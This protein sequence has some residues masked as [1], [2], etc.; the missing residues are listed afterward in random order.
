MKTSIVL[1][2][3]PEFIKLAPIARELKSRGHQFDLFLSGQHTDMLAGLPEL[4]DL[5]TDIKHLDIDYS[6]PDLSHLTSHI[7]SELNRQLFSKSSYDL[8]FVQGDTTTAFATALC[9]F[10]NK[11]PVAHVEAGLRTFD[12]QSPFPEEFNR[13]VISKLTQFHFPPTASSEQYLLDEGVEKSGI[14]RCGNTVIDALNFVREHKLHSP[15]DW[16]TTESPELAAALDSRPKQRFLITFHRRENQGNDMERAFAVI[17]QFLNENPEIEALYP[18]HLNPN[19][20]GLALKCFEKTPNM[21][22]LP[23]LSYRPFVYALSLVDYVFSDSGGLQEELPS[24][25]KPLYVLRKSTERPETIKNGYG[26]LIGTAPEAIKA[27][28]NEAKQAVAQGVAPAWYN[29]DGKNPFGDG[30]SAKQIVDFCESQL[31]AK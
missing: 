31:K 16:L 9:C 12:L 27:A 22:L 13:Q 26:K 11:V 8:V 30:S 6:K 14:L 5:A 2:T 19:V 25:A 23:P 29:T 28:L 3:R 15:E 20:R 18:I 10:Y 1:G 7:L 24:L 4:F 17:Q 21:K